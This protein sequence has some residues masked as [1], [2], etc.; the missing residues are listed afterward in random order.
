MPFAKDC[1]ASSFDGCEPFPGASLKR[2]N[3][4]APKLL[5]AVVVSL[6]EYLHARPVLLRQESI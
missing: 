3:A 6:V 1:T 5:H 4:S 2:E